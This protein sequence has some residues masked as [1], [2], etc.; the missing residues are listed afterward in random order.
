MHQ[1]YRD[2]PGGFESTILPHFV[3]AIP[4]AASDITTHPPY[5]LY[6]GRL[7]KAKGVQNI[8][9]IFRRTAR[10][11]LIAGAGSF[12]GELRRLAAGDPAIEFL[13]R[14]PHHQLSSLYRNAR[15][16]IVPSICYETFGL[17][18]LES[19]GQK[20]PVISSNF[21]ALPEV[22]EETGGGVVYRDEPELEGILDRFDAEPSFARDMGEQGAEHLEGYSVARHLD[23]Y[24]RIIRE[25][26]LEK[27]ALY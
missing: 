13:G 21:G 4:L 19:I 27:K 16:T 17:V 8:I 15:A 9:P 5:Y 2:A 6:S 11:L 12:E 10:R 7:E 23:K 22:I 26:Q 25:V 1:T 18:S 14:V 24:Y 20:T 3:P